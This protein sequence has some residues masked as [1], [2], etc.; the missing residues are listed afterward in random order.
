MPPD[1]KRPCRGF[2][3]AVF[4]TIIESGASIV[5]L[6][7]RWAAHAE[8][9]SF[10]FESGTQTLLADPVGT[11]TTVIENHGVFARGLMRTVEALH[12]RGIVV[13]IISGWPEI[14]L[15]VPQAHWTRYQLGVKEGIALRVS[16]HN[17]RQQIA[18]RALHQLEQNGFARIYDPAPLFCN[19]ALCR[20]AIADRLLY[21]DSNHLSCHGTAL[22]QKLIDQMAQD[23][24][25]AR[26]SSRGNGVGSPAPVGMLKVF[27]VME[28]NV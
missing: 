21:A 14:G 9:G 13:N 11:A 15:N 2:N 24:A 1:P 26:H 7:A 12:A 19:E 23:A 27:K 8:G 20:T 16:D 25:R 3:T 4:E 18:T 17:A 22:M 28:T 10:G 6:S 5:F